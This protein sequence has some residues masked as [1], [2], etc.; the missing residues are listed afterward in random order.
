MFKIYY[1]T[2]LQPEGTASSWKDVKCFL[3]LMPVHQ[4]Y[5]IADGKHY[6]CRLCEVSGNLKKVAV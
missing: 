1:Q 3:M 4:C 5:V 2:E 6:N